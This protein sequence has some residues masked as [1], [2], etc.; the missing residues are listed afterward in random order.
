VI[1]GLWEDHFNNACQACE[2]PRLPG[3]H[4]SVMSNIRAQHASLA[5]GLHGGPVHTCGLMHRI[6]D[7][8]RAGWV[9]HWRHVADD[10]ARADDLQAPATKASPVQPVAGTA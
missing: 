4:Q 2:D 1:R 6:V 10:H 9:R 7:N 5:A 8:R 3:L